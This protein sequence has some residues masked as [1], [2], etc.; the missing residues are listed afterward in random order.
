MS[1]NTDY[2]EK[3]SEHTQIPNP[4]GLKSETTSIQTPRSLS[5]GNGH[6]R[7]ASKS[8]VTN[9]QTG[10]EKAD[11][12]QANLNEYPIGARMFFIIVALVLG[13]FLVSLN[14]TMIATT[15]PKITSQFYSLKDVS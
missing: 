11:P 15:I 6:E 4:S 9:F 2:G 13:I 5:G 8:T 14:L 3:K 12:N 7:K 1:S 10:E